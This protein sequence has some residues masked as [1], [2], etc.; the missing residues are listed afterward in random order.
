MM[1]LHLLRFL[2]KRL[3]NVL[4]WNEETLIDFNRVIYTPMYSEWTWSSHM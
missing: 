3:P 4:S 2:D 1:P